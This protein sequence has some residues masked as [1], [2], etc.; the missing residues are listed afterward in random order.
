[1][2]YCIIYIIY[3]I[4]ILILVY[5]K[6]KKNVLDNKCIIDM[7]FFY[8]CLKYKKFNCGGIWNKLIKY[9]FCIYN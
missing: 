3:Y 8:Y 5:D 2:W 7:L 1:M 6:I 4:I 9:V